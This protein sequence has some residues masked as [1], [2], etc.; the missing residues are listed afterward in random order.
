SAHPAA[1]R[2]PTPPTVR[3]TLA[4]TRIVPTEGRSETSRQLAWQPVLTESA[5]AGVTVNYLNVTLRD[6]ATGALAEPQGVESLSAEEIAAAAGSN[7]LTVPGT[8]VVPL[9]LTFDNDTNGGR[10]A[11][12]AQLT[13]VNGNGFGVPAP[14]PGGGSSTARSR[15]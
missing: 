1:G 9:T 10:P 12:A 7:R 5:G 11:N 15:S 4:A 8:L 13:P 14:A 2:A 3:R 6:A